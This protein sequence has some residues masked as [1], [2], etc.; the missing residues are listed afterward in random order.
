MTTI[1]IILLVA[2]L[3]ALFVVWRQKQA[4]LEEYSPVINV[5]AEV[6]RV[7]EEAARLRSATKAEMDALRERTMADL[8][9]ARKQRSDLSQEYASARQVYDQLREKVSR[10]EESIEDISV[11]LY[12]PHYKFDSSEAYKQ[13][14]A[15][16]R[17]Q[18]KALARAGRAAVCSTVWNIGGDAKAGQKMTKLYLK[19]M[20]RA[21]NG[22]CDAAIARVTWNNILKMETR[23]RETWTSINEFGQVMQMQITPEY[24]DL[25]HAEL[26]LEFE[27]DQKKHDEQEQQR[28]IREQMREEERALREAEKAKR[29]AEEEEDRYQKALEKAKQ[30]L[31]KAKGDSIE[32]LNTKI[33]QLDAALHK[34]QEQ[35]EKANSMAQLTRSGYV[36]VI[37]N[38]GSFGDDIF[39]IGMTRRLDPMDRIWELSDA[40]VPFDFDVHAMIY[41]VDA[42]SLEYAFQERFAARAV[43]LVNDRKEFF[44]VSIDEIE[45]LAK[46]RGLE[47]EFTKLAE[48]REYKETLARRVEMQRATVAPGPPPL[49]EELPTSI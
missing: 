46:E 5:R 36:Y 29:E 13:A 25:K 37:S 30:E 45:T 16:V 34:A 35:K 23:I 48:A 20:L 3:V 22:E 41:S 14:L 19:L 39:K 26:R 7:R 31:A 2:A 28:R 9:T 4:L 11:G 42:P 12:A 43:N 47:V 32:L 10:L 21:F 17:D 33:A 1:P 49:A 44:S 27:T 24:L 38:L 18:Q 8:A 15:E 6:K 40:S